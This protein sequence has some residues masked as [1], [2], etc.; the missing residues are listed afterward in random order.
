MQD[1]D[2]RP[3]LFILKIHT[4]R[5]H[6]VCSVWR[7]L[8]CDHT[9]QMTEVAPS[10]ST[11]G[12]FCQP[13]SVL[14]R[15]K[16]LES[17]LAPNVWFSFFSYLFKNNCFRSIMEIFRY[18]W[19]IFQLSG[20]PTSRS[21]YCLQTKTSCNCKS[22]LQGRHVTRKWP[23]MPLFAIMRSNGCTELSPKKKHNWDPHETQLNT[24]KWEAGFLASIDNSAPQERCWFF[25]TSI[26]L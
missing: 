15:K 19:V 16:L 11:R 3:T 10:K 22:D 7:G 18:C 26:K 20:P 1:G 6:L 9:K 14:P 4:Y 5:S 21:M 12:T 13:Y 24:G 2:H 8:V 25:I 17:M 23:S